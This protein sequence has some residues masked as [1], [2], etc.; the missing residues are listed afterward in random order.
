MTTEHMPKQDF[1]YHYKK[2]PFLGSF[3]SRKVEFIKY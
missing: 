3:I 2:V 1:N